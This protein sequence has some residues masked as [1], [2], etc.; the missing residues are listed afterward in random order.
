MSK[1]KM[2]SST[3]TE[4]PEG[5]YSVNTVCAL[6][7]QPQNKPSK[8]QYVGVFQNTPAHYALIERILGLYSRLDRTDYS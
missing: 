2:P 5:Q 3:G 8:R 4:P 6:A 7:F 1:S